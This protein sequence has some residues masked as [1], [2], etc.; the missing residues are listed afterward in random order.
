VSE[1]ADALVIFGITG[2]LAKRMTLRS[3]YRLEARGRLDCP[4]V[5]VAAENWTQRRLIEHADD[6]IAAA[7]EHVDPTVFRRLA[8][9]LSY[10]SG[11]L[12]D[13]PT[14]ARVKSALGARAGRSST[15]RSR[16]RCLRPSSRA[17][18]RS[19]RC[20]RAPAS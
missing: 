4:I 11:D 12:G 20:R 3:L 9:R 5:G 1:R 17:S 2:N 16:R 19:T 18:R 15:W 13:A 14:F 8:D 6:A 7:G 10:V